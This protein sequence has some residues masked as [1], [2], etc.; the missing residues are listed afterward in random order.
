MQLKASLLTVLLTAVHLSAR[1][2][3]ALDQ[4]FQQYLK[5]DASNHSARLELINKS[6]ATSSDRENFQAYKAQ[7]AELAALGRGED[8]LKALD[9]Y[10]DLVSALFD[11]W[12]TKGNNAFADPEEYKRCREYQNNCMLMKADTH[13]AKA[14]VFYDLGKY[15]DAMHEWSTMCAT[16]DVLMK[17]LDKP[18]CNEQYLLGK[19]E[20][21]LKFGN[22]PDVSSDLNRYIS[23]KQA[24][25]PQPTVANSLVVPGLCRAS[26]LDNIANYDE[27]IGALDT[28]IAG[29]TDENLAMS[30]KDAYYVGGDGLG[31][32]HEKVRLPD[33]I[34][35]RAQVKEKAGKSADALT[36]YNLLVDKFSSSPESAKYLVYRAKYQADHG[37]TAAAQTDFDQAVAKASDSESLIA[38]ALFEEKCRKTSQAESD[39][40]A[41]TKPTDADSY[42]PL[43][44]FYQRN[45]QSIK[46]E[47][48]LEKAVQISQTVANSGVK[49]LLMRSAIRVARNQNAEALADLTAALPLVIHQTSSLFDVLVRRA[50]VH[51]LL[52]DY[53]SASADLDSAG[54]I[55]AN[56]AAL[57]VAKGKVADRSGNQDQAKRYYNDTCS[58]ASIKSSADHIAVAEAAIALNNLQLAKQELSNAIKDPNELDYEMYS[59]VLLQRASVYTLLTENARVLEDVQKALA[60][61]PDCK[62]QARLVKNKVLVSMGKSPEAEP[63]AVPNATKGTTASSKDKPGTMPVASTGKTV[64]NTDTTSRAKNDLVSQEKKNP[65]TD[66]L[67]EQALTALGAKNYALAIQLLECSLSIAPNDLATKR[68]L[69]VAYN[70]F[71]QSELQSNQDFAMKHFNKAKE[72]VSKS[73][74]PQFIAGC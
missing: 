30:L 48:N 72:L 43:I 56:S 49:P 13:A 33:A 24:H 26:L 28:V 45:N 47:Q 31:L 36:D 39:F 55:S 38:R 51:T 41:A 34:L 22:R 27:E 65:A 63:Q 44:N 46:A 32:F 2:A 12:C 11:E 60:I 50:A 10:L 16:K 54:K 14:R 18:A 68:N 9:N 52:G 59:D 37:N 21:E 20:I 29:W 71:G 69:S 25:Q 7:A 8:A 73:N 67:N 5:T 42:I 74:G 40:V 1:P 17:R 6:L 3:A 61:N 53:A 4:Y 58:K 15:S 70:S 57:L 35:M 23:Y 19:A 66:K 62:K 64:A